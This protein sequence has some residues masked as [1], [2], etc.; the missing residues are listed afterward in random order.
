ML[1]IILNLIQK[2]V[3]WNLSFNSY[4]NFEGI[5]GNL[6]IWQINA[7]FFLIFYLF[8][9]LYNSTTSRY[10]LLKFALFLSLY[11]YYVTDFIKIW[12]GEVK[13]ALKVC[14]S[15]MKWPPLTQMLYTKNMKNKRNSNALKFYKSQG[16][17]FIFC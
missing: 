12:D 11:E 16:F 5:Y 8:P 3:N 2:T 13:F 14:W 15:D 6:N 17:K 10:I 9:G 4:C 7:H 1:N